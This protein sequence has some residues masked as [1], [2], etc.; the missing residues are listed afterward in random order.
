MPIG[1]SSTNA[2]TAFLHATGQLLAEQGFAALNVEAVA[3]LAG[4]NKALIYRYFCGLDGL[5]LAYAATDDFLPGAEELAS[6]L[7]PD[8]LSVPPRRRLA[9]V[10]KAFAMGLR[11]RPASVQILLHAAGGRNELARTLEAGRRPRIQAIRAALHLRDDD[12][13][14]DMDAVMTLF[15]SAFVLM[16]ANQSRAAAVLG[17]AGA[18][19]LWAR[20]DATIDALLG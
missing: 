18:D 14:M 1:D 12:V 9:A 17:E 10:L 13:G 3:R 11:K 4:F 8:P 15:L 16:V 5:V 20:I 19:A 2:R 6:H 7:P